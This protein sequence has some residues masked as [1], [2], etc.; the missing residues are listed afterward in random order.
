MN[1][2]LS[3]FSACNLVLSGLKIFPA[4]LNIRST[5]AEDAGIDREFFAARAT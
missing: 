1:M 5:G 4:M 2:R 3:N